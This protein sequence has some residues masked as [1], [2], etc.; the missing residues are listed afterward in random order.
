[1]KIKIVL[2]ALICLSMFN[3]CSLQNNEL[4]ILDEVFN[5]REYIEDFNVKLLDNKSDTLPVAKRVLLANSPAFK[6]YAYATIRPFENK[7][8]LVA[9]RFVSPSDWKGGEI[10]MMESLDGGITWSKEK[11]IQENI[12]LIQTAAPS[13]ISVNETLMLFFLVKNSSSQCHVYFKKS[14]D[15]G[16]SWT[17]PV[18]VSSVEGYNIINNDRCIVVNDRII[19]PVAFTPEIHHYYQK[20]GIFCYYS[21]DYGKSWKR[22]SSIATTIPLMEPGIVHLGGAELL[23]VIRSNKGKILFSRSFD[24]GINWTIPVST[25]INSPEAPSTIAKLPEDSTLILIWNNNPATGLSKRNPLTMAFSKDKGY[26]WTNPFMI[27]YLKNSDFAYSSICFDSQKCHVT[28]TQIPY[29]SEFKQNVKYF[30][31]EIE[32]MKNLSRNPY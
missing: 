32:T 27:E 1:M 21:D 10:I 4:E 18:K 16:Y 2:T 30:N 25:N 19:V 15:K 8:I 31:I 3:S 7:L 6:G 26:T 5:E 28:Y 20:Q 14:F 23:M 11:A 29:S 9:T 13:L 24:R 22:S 17:E 12:G